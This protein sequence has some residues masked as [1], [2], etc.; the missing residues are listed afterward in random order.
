M[1][2]IVSVI[3]LAV[4]AVPLASAFLE[5]VRLEQQTNTVHNVLSEH[6][7]PGEVVDLKLTTTGDPFEVH[8]TIRSV[9]WL[10]PVDVQ[11]AQAAL[12]DALGEDVALELTNVRAIEP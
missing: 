10:T 3:V 11:E 1:N 7:S 5:V 6:F 2:W 4:L 8:A 9:E 12:S